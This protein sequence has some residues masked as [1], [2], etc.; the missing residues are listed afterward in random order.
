MMFA[1]D[2]RGMISYAFMFLAWGV[3]AG[4]IVHRQRRLAPMVI[5]HWIVNIALGV[6][7]MIAIAF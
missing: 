5:A 6:G 4:I 1:G 2:V 7:P 3:T